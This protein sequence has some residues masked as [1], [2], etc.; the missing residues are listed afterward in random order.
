[1]CPSAVIVSGPQAQMGEEEQVKPAP[2]P[3]LDRLGCV[4]KIS[5]RSVQG[6]DFH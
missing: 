5:S 2:K 3:L 4:F 1:M 6:L